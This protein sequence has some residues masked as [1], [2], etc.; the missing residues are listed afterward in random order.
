[1]SPWEKFLVVTVLEL[2]L[3]IFLGVTR[4]R[5]PGRVDRARGRVV[6]VALLA[7]LFGVDMR[8]A[9]GAWL[10]S[11]IAISSGAAAAYVKEGYRSQRRSELLAGA[12][13]AARVPT[14]AIAVIQ[15]SL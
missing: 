7:L 1:M 9:I 5:P 2:T 11:V 15:G 4:D 14:S 12:W 10:V 3:L 13:L 6:L 8:Y